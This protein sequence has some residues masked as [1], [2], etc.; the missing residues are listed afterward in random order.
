MNNR[1]SH[2]LID[3]GKPMQISK[4]MPINQCKLINI[5]SISDDRGNVSFFET[6]AIADFDIKRIYYL[7]GITANAM[8]GMHAHK[9]LRSI[10]IAVSGAFKV[11][12]DDGIEQKEFTLSKPNQGLYL[13][14]M[15]WRDLYDFSADA[16]AMIIAN[17]IY[18]EADYIRDYREFLLLA[19]SKGI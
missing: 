1:N 7:H 8:R 15:I 9:E 17:Q 12:I 18:D 11:K 2:S 4:N 3:S 10:I 5:P 6:G 13:T 16:V 19:N 14:N